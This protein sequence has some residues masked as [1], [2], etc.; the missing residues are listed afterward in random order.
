MISD[1]KEVIRKWGF[2]RLFYALDHIILCRTIMDDNISLIGVY[3]LL[4]PTII[5]K[6]QSLIIMFFYSL[7]KKLP[8]TFIMSVFL[9]YCAQ[10]QLD[11]DSAKKQKF[12]MDVASWGFGMGLDYGGLGVNLTIYPQKNIGIF[13]GLGY[14]FVGAGYNV[15]IRT[16]ITFN[17]VKPNP[18]LFITGMY[19]YNTVYKVKDW[20]ALDRKYYGYTVGM[21]IETAVRSSKPGV[22]SFGLLVPIRSQEALS[23]YDQLKKNPY[24]KMGNLLP[25]AISIGYK[26]RLG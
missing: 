11:A 24:I 13:G 1:L 8:L 12:P 20:S 6:N 5:P 2:L 9:T 16:R 4:S 25:F 19:G 23:Y 17:K 3:I 10:A 22:W 21:G 14:A 18:S 7:S 15:G 26:I